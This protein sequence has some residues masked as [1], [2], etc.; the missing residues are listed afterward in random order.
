MIDRSTISEGLINI[1][2]KFEES[3]LLLSAET[4]MGMLEEMQKFVKTSM[5]VMLLE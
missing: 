3:K 4:L 1:A 5:G 2:S